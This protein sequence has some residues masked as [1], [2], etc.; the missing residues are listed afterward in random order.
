M[1][2]FPWWTVCDPVGTDPLLQPVTDESDELQIRCA[3]NIL[4]TKHAPIESRP[5]DSL[6]ISIGRQV[7]RPRSHKRVLTADETY[8]IE[9]H[10]HI[11]EGMTRAFFSDRGLKECLGPCRHDLENKF[12]EFEYCHP[13]PSF[14]DAWQRYNLLQ[15]KQNWD[16]MV[17]GTYW[18]CSPWHLT[19]GL[20]SES[21]DDDTYGDSG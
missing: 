12:I 19:D 20:L 17:H 5:L 8:D 1:G 16:V 13:H 9:F 14:I 10:A 18:E 15:N 3:E 21:N 11:C 6:R 4:P 7:S 2:S